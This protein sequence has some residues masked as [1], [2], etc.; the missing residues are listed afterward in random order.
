MPK[1]TRW[2]CCALGAALLKALAGCAVAPPEAGPVPAVAEA[3]RQG[4]VVAAAAA[5]PGDGWWRAFD[6]TQLDA[7][8][9]LAERD[10][11][12]LQ[13]AAARVAQAAALWRASGAGGRSQ[14]SASAGAT[15]DTGPRVN[16]AGSRGNL[17]DAG[18]DLQVE[19]DLLRR[20]SR[21][22]QAAAAD[23]QAQQLQAAQAR[24]LMQ[25]ALAQAWLQWRAT[26]QD[27]ALQQQ[28]VQRSRELLAL[29]EGRH[30]AGLVAA[31]ALTPLRGDL[32]ADDVELQQV[33]LR[34]ETLEHTLA[35]LTG[36]PRLS[37]NLDAVAAV[38]PRLPQ[39]PAG[40]PSQMLQRRPD[41]AAAERTLQA[42]RLRL[43][44]AR[45]AWFPALTLTAHAGLASGDLSQWLKSAAR[46][47]GLGALLALPLLDGGR[48]D[49][50][51][52]AAAA[53]V[54]QA[55]AEHRER[56][57]AALREVDDQLATLRALAAE[58]VQVEAASDDAA[59]DADRAAALQ[60]QG[61]Q[62]AADTLRARRA[63]LREQ[64]RWLQVQTAQRV[65]TVGLVR[66]LGGG[67]GDG[68]PH[69]ASAR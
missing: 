11:P 13:Q 62:P 32:R 57:L 26:V 60:V 45:D 61:L 68:G 66:A 38:Q 63:E 12:G 53:G 25:A 37:L 40:L 52:E 36:Q 6:D 43:G 48:Q 67:W 35:A 27:Q 54:A 34:R 55:T 49:A 31:Q 24:L 10:N 23:L 42:A 39:V 65:A 3:F 47:L 17:F 51:R 50:A 28:A 18:I 21:Q 30:L 5:L 29:A 22:E 20:T 4:P 56:V 7:L 2:M 46:G 8:M 58:A 1:L 59:R 33:T 64:R 19:L 16:A 44:V 9:A 15:R 69:L 41:V 14:L